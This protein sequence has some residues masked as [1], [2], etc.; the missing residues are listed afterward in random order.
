MIR[1]FC[2]AGLMAAVLVTPSVVRADDKDVIDYRQHIMKTL[3][4]QTAIIGQLVSGAAPEE[5]LK[6]HAEAISLA[7]KIALKSFEAKVPGGE[8]KP[9]V[10]SKWDDFSKRMKAFSTA[11]DKL[12][13]STQK[14]ASMAEVTAMLVEVLPCKE[15]HD[16][17]R[18]EQK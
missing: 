16:V 1:T 7:A 17:Y 13:D 5:N 14:G 12:A 8:S 11:A 10:W 9:E 4:E 18:E 3:Q 6:Y 15:C 2:G